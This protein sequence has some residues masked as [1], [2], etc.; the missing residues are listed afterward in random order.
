MLVNFR[1][2][3]CWLIIVWVV[4]ETVFQ[5]KV[6][7]AEQGPIFLNGG[8]FVFHHVMDACA[9]K[10]QKTLLFKTCCSVDCKK[11]RIQMRRRLHSQSTTKSPDSLSESY[12]LTQH[13]YTW[14]HLLLSPSPLVFLK[15]GGD[16][17]PQC[18]P[19]MKT[20]IVL[21]KILHVAFKALFVLE[22]DHRQN[23]P[24][25][26]NGC[27]CTW[28]L[29]G[30]IILGKPPGLQHCFPSWTK[31]IAPSSVHNYT[32]HTA[33]WLCFVRLVL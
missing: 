7:S 19:I 16:W 26:E 32:L 5:R 28:L 20:F 23:S 1:K 2:R 33:A 24:Y 14:C 13:Q 18:I 29:E 25:R 22:T 21:L 15:K 4:R 10:L 3:Q 27:L 9:R 11:L 6:S 30:F 17:M 31:H 12:T 8:Q